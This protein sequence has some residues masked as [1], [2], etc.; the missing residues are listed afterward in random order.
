MLP[1][2]PHDS[3]LGR[4]QAWYLLCGDPHQI[5]DLGQGGRC[6]ADPSDRQALKLIEL[7]FHFV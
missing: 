7:S 6:R 2:D 5:R 1:L 4:C 3:R